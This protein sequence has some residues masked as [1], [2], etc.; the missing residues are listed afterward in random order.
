MTSPTIS[1]LEEPR[2]SLRN[3]MS[4]LLSLR[5]KKKK[6]ARLICRLCE[7][8]ITTENKKCACLENDEHV[9]GKDLQRILQQDYDDPE[10][11]I[12]IHNVLHLESQPEK[13]TQFVQKVYDVVET[14]RLSE[15]LSPK[16]FRYLKENAVNK[17]CMQLEHFSLYEDS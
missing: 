11:S 5:K 4:N 14:T 15:D 7:K 17:I 8:E 2:L 12:H 1:L 3:L 6:D 13:L 9:N 16:S 10:K